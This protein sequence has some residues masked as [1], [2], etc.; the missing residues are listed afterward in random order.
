MKLISNTIYIVLILLIT[1]CSVDDSSDDQSFEMLPIESITFPEEF[2]LNEI[3]D[4]DFTFIRPTNC[5]G[6]YDILINADDANRTVGVTSIVY[7]NSNCIELTEDNLAEQTF[8]FQVLYDQ[9]YVFHIWKG[10]DASGAD[11]FE[12]IEIP[13]VN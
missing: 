11:V 9:T 4:I 5:H 6:Y 8:R 2:T 7:E 13:V 1:S 12:D 10:T 3:Y